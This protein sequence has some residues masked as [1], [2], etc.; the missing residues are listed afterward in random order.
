MTN[1]GAPARRP[2]LVTLLIVLVVIGG[3]LSVIGG[4][5]LI[6]LK[7][8]P[9]V[10]VT[11]GSSGV[12]L[13]AGIGTIIV[14][15]IYLAVAK[16]L[17]NGNGFSRLIVAIVSLVSIIGGFWVGITQIGNG[18]ISGWSSVFWGVIILLILYSP[19]ANAFFRTN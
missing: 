15:L 19:R 6:F 12:G 14:G 1:T 18:A 4:I 16:G 17:S 11:T 9:D 8:N 2:G 3:V 7:D 10:V 13:W 5:A